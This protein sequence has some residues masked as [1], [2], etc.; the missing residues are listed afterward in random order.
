MAIEQPLHSIDTVWE[1]VN[2]PENDDMRFYL[3]DGELFTF[4]RARYYVAGRVVA[5][6]SF[7][8]HSFVDEHNLGMS[9]LGTGHHP[10][11]DRYTLL[12]PAVSFTSKARLPSPLPDGYMPVM[13]D[14]AV[15]IAAPGET[16]G[17]LRRKA[18]VY[19]KDETALVWIVLPSEKGVDVCR[20]AVGARLDIEFIGQDGKLSGDDVLPGFELELSKLF[21]VSEEA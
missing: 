12:G 21:P 19:L 10:P 4:P 20:S 17:H 9:L 3:I 6:M 8:V 16:L 1:L 7:A 18:Q 2:A 5:S 15:E 14:L 13:P 11:D